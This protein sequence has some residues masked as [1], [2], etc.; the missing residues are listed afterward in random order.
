MTAGAELLGEFHPELFSEM[1]R[2]VFV[3]I[4]LGKAHL[5]SASFSVGAYVGVSASKSV[6][7]L[8]T[9]HCTLLLTADDADFMFNLLLDVAFR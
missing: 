8:R 5:F 4:M 1:L 6:P 9:C 7:D 2:L 3:F